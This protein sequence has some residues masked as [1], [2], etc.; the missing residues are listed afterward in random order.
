M[1]TWDILISSIPHRHDQL[2]GLLKELDSQLP[3]PGVG[4]HLYRDNLEAT[5]GEKAAA[6]LASSAADYVSYID[7]DDMPAPDYVARITAALAE[8][9]D[10][11]GYPVRWT[12]DGELQRP[13]EHSLRHG[14]WENLPDMLV[15]DISEKNPLRRE[16]AWTGVWVG[17]YA[18]EQQWAAG[19][20][21]SG[22]V[23]TEV[24]IDEPMYYYQYSTSDRFTMVRHPM[25]ELPPLP[26]YPWLTVL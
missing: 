17:G 24:W 5:Y 19:V 6:L 16:L 18:A 4:V 23:K 8:G 15:R 13:V 9:P 25:L 7:D 2:C 1:T 10:Y 3:A 26:S 14:R 12:I 22:L 21:A 20:R 11:V